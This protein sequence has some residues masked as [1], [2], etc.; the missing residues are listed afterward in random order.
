MN[1]RRVDIVEDTGTSIS[2]EIDVGQ[3]EGAYVMALGLWLT[4]QVRYDPDTGKLLTFDTWVMTC[5]INFT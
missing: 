2:P 5:G 3:V 4:E 1:I